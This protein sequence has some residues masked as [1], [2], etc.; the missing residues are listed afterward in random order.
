MAVAIKKINWATPGDDLDVSVDD[1]RNMIKQA[2]SEKGMSFSEYTKKVNV[3]LK[4][5]L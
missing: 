4:N 5:S 2:E 1:Y 3:W